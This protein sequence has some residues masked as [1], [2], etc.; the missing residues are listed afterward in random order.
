MH[1]MQADQCLEVHHV[2]RPAL[3]AGGGFRGSMYP[4]CGEW[5]AGYVDGVGSSSGYHSCQT[6]GGTGC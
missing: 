5:V 6:V 4:A 1:V 3:S 2:R